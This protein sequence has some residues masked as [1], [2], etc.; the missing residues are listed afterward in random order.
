METTFAQ[1]EDEP[2]KERLCGMCNKVKIPADI[3][4]CS[5]CSVWMDMICQEITFKHN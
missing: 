5:K 2:K 1:P 4:T 3:T